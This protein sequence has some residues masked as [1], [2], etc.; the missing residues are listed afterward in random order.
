MGTPDYLKLLL[1]NL[2]SSLFAIAIDKWGTGTWDFGHI[3]ATKYVGP[4]SSVPVDESCNIG[5]SWRVANISAQFPEGT[6]PQASCGMF[7]ESSITCTIHV[8][9]VASCAI[10]RLS[11]ITLP[12]DT[13]Y[14]LMN[15]DSAIVSRYYQDVP[16]ANTVTASG[17]YTFPCNASLPDLDLT[18]D[19]SG[20]TIRGHVLNYHPYDIEANSKRSPLELPWN[21]S[22]FSSKT[23]S[24]DTKT[25][26]A[27][28]RYRALATAVAL[29]SAKYS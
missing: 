12:T 27:W 26:S 15:L 23:I 1:P 16:G 21:S 8:N 18:I 7:G 10:K 25:Q 3:N 11:N 13:G 28:V 17:T 19:G 22:S 29:S 2:G 5:G 14:D 9:Y 24:A 20:A 4:L 6:M